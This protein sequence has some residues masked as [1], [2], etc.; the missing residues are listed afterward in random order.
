[1][2]STPQSGNTES[3]RSGE[4]PSGDPL[5]RDTGTPSPRYEVNVC[6]A[7]ADLPPR[8]ELLFSKAARSS[9][10]FTLPWFRHY[11][12]SILTAHDHLRI[13]SVETATAEPEARAV[14]I[15]C[16]RSRSAGPFSYRKLVGLGNYYTSLFGIVM[17]PCQPDFQQVYRVLA[18]AVA[19][20]SMRWNEIDLHPLAADE[21]H[22]NALIDAFR[23]AGLLVQTYFCFGNWY[24]EVN[25]QTFREYFRSRPSRLIN[26]EKRKRK[27]L[28]S[29]GH[30]RFT[31]YSDLD[32]L[33][34]AIADYNQVYNSSWKTREPY[35]DFV[36][37]LIRCCAEQGWL[38]LGI[39]YFDGQPAAAQI[40]IVVGGQASIYK[41]AYDE[42]FAKYSIGTVISS[43]LM[44]HALDTDKVEV[45]DYLTGDDSYKREWMSQRRERW[46]IR[47]FNPR[48]PYGLLAAVRHVGGRAIRRAVD[49]VRNLRAANR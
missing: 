12:K 19:G 24:H 49:A 13:Y 44:E 15:M 46:G 30:F 33:D 1:M 35:P 2:P 32:G 40:W 21:P 47:A 39:G 27:A 43:M 37:D 22:F 17:D 26:T 7:L 23:Q 11:T 42:Q 38:R 14:L 48:T 20:D 28:E 5:G 45:V 18:T 6:D 34:R 8:Y 16:Y 36:G 25:K 4:T 9:I 29:G 10:F 3:K 31:L 41:L